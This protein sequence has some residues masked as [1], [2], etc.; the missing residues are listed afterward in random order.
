MTAKDGSNGMCMKH[1]CYDGV[2]VLFGFLVVVRR[3]RNEEE[4]QT[5][6]AGLVG[7]CRAAP[8]IDHDQQYMLVPGIM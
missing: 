8:Q 7:A 1:Q 6:A 4:M 5:D 3:V 2:G